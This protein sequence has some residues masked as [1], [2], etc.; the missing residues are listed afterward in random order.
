MTDQQTIDRVAVG[1]AELAIEWPNVTRLTLLCLLLGIH[2][3]IS[4]WAIKA[5]A[6]HTGTPEELVAK[7]RELA[8][9]AR[10]AICDICGRP[11]VLEPEGYWIHDGTLCLHNAKPKGET[12]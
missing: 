4:K 9:K 11:I 2:E 7:L 12:E 3:P 8:A 1:L 6:D 5:L 10:K